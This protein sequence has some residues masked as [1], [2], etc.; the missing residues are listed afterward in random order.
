MNANEKN[1]F[2][3][4][5]IRREIKDIADAAKRRRRQGLAVVALGL[6]VA[7]IAIVAAVIAMF[8]VTTSF[9]FLPKAG[10]DYEG[11]QILSGQATLAQLAEEASR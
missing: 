5:R 4:G 7:V 8:A 9:Q 11:M 2:D 6:A 1:P 10:L 3:F